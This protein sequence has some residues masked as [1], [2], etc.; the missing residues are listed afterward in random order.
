MKLQTWLPG[1]LSKMSDRYSERYKTS[2]SLRDKNKADIF[3]QAANDPTEA[4]L[5][6]AARLFGH[7]DYKFGSI[8]ISA[9]TGE[10]TVSI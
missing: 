9:E 3:S 4:N 6:A 5:L 7:G 2:H 1:F 8:G 10:V